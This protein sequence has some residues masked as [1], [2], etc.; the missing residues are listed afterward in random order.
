MVRCFDVRMNYPSRRMGMFTLK[1]LFL[2]YYSKSCKSSYA[3][4]QP[5]SS[6]TPTCDRSTARAL[7]E[8]GGWSQRREPSTP[9][10]SLN[11]LENQ[12]ITVHK[13]TIH[14]T[15]R[16]LSQDAST[17]PSAGLS[18]SNQTQ[19][20]L[21]IPPSTCPLQLDRRRFVP[22]TIGSKCNSPRLPHRIY[23]T[24]SE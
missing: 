10:F 23:P 5:A 2:L 19:H 24:F 17:I 12:T 18:R 3:T 20:P 11:D 21:F 9:S 22:Q 8:G 6:P 14:S 7:T 16:L 1:P 4:I 15:P 13:P